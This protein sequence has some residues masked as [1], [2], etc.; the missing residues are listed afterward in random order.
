MGVPAE[1]IEAAVRVMESGRLFRYSAASADTSEVSNA[2]AEFAE[3][4][5]AKYA[6]AV[7]S[8]TSAIML[9]L[10]GA[11]VEAGDEVLTNGFTFTALPSTNLPYGFP[12]QTAGAKAFA[13]KWRRP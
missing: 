2:E 6:I 1:G 3:M 11:G 4:A 12:V 9:T 8:C 10:L 13:R 5:G 7:N